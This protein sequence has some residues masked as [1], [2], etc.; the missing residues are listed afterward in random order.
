MADEQVR[1]EATAA[2][3]EVAEAVQTFLGQAGGPSGGDLDKTRRRHIIDAAHKL[4]NAVKDPADEWFDVTAQVAQLGASRLFWEWKAYD[5]IPAEGSVSYAELAGA[6]EAEESL[7]RRIGGVLTSTGILQQVGDDAVAHTRRSRVYVD[8]HPAGQIVGMAWEN[9]L[10]PYVHMPA[11]FE[12]YGRKEPQSL[13]HVP[14]TFAYGRPE[15]GWYEMLQHDPP[16]MRR[17]LRAMGPIEEKMPISGIY[18]F[19]WVVDHARASPA[20]RVLLVDVGAGRGQS[21]KAIHRENPDLPLARCVL[22]DRPEVVEAVEALDDEDMRAV[23]KQVID[24]HREQPVK[25]ALTYWIRRCLHNHGDEV[26]VN[27]LRIIADAM[28]DDSRLL[29]QEDVMGNPPHYTSTMLDFM[30]LTF[31]GKQRSLECWTDVLG[32]AGLEIRS[33]ATGQGPWRHLAVLE[34]VKK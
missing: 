27:M 17:F 19:S 2:A 22:Q 16:R 20:D 12:K 5:R 1:A 10:V 4:I 18:D 14:G 29:I 26:A 34:C 30:M 9:G 33:V 25:G 3:D 15:Y 23:R 13:N 32:R 6:V 7:I 31:G 24:F 11:Y 28:A 8:G 21:I